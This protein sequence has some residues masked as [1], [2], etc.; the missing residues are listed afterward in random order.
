MI[1]ARQQVGAKS[2]HSAVPCRLHNELRLKRKQA[3]ERAHDR[4]ASDA[5]SLEL[6]HALRQIEEADE[7]IG[8]AARVQAADDLVTDCA[9]SDDGE[10]LQSALAGSPGDHHVKH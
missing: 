7:R 9:K 4:E 3:L 2:R 5:F 8:L 6:R 10:P 1:S